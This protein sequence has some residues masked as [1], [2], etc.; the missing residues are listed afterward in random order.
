MKGFKPRKCY[1]P[2]K[3]LSLQWFLVIRDYSHKNL[4]LKEALGGKGLLAKSDF[5]H[6]SAYQ[7]T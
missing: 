6:R 1:K 3:G 7:K 2:Y 5:F 4:S